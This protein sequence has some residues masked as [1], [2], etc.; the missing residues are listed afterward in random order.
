MKFEDKEILNE[1]YQTEIR[2]IFGKQ[3][4]H[5]SI[6]NETPKICD[7]FDSNLLKSL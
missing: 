4:A 3:K 7:F 2:T 1:N 5:W 6:C